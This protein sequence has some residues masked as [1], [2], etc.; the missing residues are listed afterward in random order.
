MDDRSDCEI[1]DGTVIVMKRLEGRRILVTGAGSGIGQATALR[2]LDEGA[3]V[4]GADISAEGLQSTGQS[5]QEAGTADRFTA[6]TMNIGDEAS[7]VAGARSAVETLGGLDA[8]VNAAGM[9]RA[10]HTHEM[11]LQDWN[12]IIT[13]N[14]TGTFLVI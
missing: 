13:V 7:V 14:L 1:R 10:V 8:V 4:V 9:L 3:A 5:A 6:L 11:S 2:L 12:Q